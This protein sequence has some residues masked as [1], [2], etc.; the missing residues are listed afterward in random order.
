MESCNGSIFFSHC[1]PIPGT[2]LTS[3]KHAGPEK[4]KLGMKSDVGSEFYSI[5]GRLLGYR[6]VAPGRCLW[7]GASTVL[8]ADMG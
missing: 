2:D 3:S 7:A 8:S 5:S 1:L 6:D 4:A